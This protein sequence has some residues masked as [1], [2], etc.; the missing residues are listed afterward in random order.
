MSTTGEIGK[1]N[2]KHH[3]TCKIVQI[4]GKSLTGEKGL[5]NVSLCK[6]VVMHPQDIK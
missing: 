1:Q 5:Q 3:T 4:K 6:K 2:T